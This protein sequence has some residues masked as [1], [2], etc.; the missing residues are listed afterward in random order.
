MTHLDKNSTEIAQNATRPAAMEIAM[1]LPEILSNV[2]Y[3]V[4]RSSLRACLQVSRHWYSCGR[5]ISWQTFRIPLHLFACLFCKPHDLGS[6]SVDN[7][8]IRNFLDG[9]RHIRSL[10]LDEPYIRDW[11]TTSDSV[12][13]MICPKIPFVLEVPDLSN[14]MHFAV[15]VF[16][17]I[18]Q[19][20][21]RLGKLLHVAQA[22]LLQ[23]PG[24]R[25]L[26]WSTRSELEQDFVDIVLKRASKHLKKLSLE[27]P[28]RI[29]H[30]LGYLIDANMK[31]LRGEQEKDRKKDRRS[32]VQSE[33]SQTEE[34]VLDGTGKENGE[35]QS[36]NDNDDTMGGCELEELVL[37][38]RD[39]GHERHF[40]DPPVDLTWLHDVQGTLPIHT[41]TMIDLKL[42]ISDDP[43]DEDSIQ[44]DQDSDGSLLTILSKCP[45][46]EKLCVTSNV[47]WDWI[48]CVPRTFI[49][50]IRRSLPFIKSSKLDHV[51]FERDEFVDLMYE[52]CPKLRDIEFAMAY[53]LSA[54]HW[55]EM[56]DKYGSQLESL[57]IWGNVLEFNSTALMTLI[58][59]PIS[60]PSRKTLHCLTRLNING[61]EH[62]HDSAWMVLQHLPQLKEF[63]ARDIPLDARELI[64]DGGWACK[65]LEV[66]EIFIA[67][68]TKPQWIWHEPWNN[69]MKNDTYARTVI[70]M[71][72]SDI[73]GRNNN[74][75][76]QLDVK[77]A[78]KRRAE[79]TNTGSSR[80][81]RKSDKQ[82]EEEKV[83]TKGKEPRKHPRQTGVGR[84]GS[85]ESLHTVIQ[86]QVCR[87]LGLLTQLRELKIE[88][89]KDF[90]FASRTWDCLDLTLETGLG[91]LAPLR[92]NLE[93]LNVSSLQNGLTGRKEVEWIARNWIH[94]NNPRWLKRYSKLR[95]P[96]PTPLPKGV[97]GK[98]GPPGT[99]SKDDDILTTYQRP[100]FTEL[101]GI[102]IPYIGK[103]KAISNMA[104]LLAQCPS[105]SIVEVGGRRRKH[106]WI[107]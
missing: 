46:L 4:D 99:G 75:C 60:H 90:R 44:D 78:L 47:N 17:T 3:F 77:G 103:E 80:K 71:N 25:E 83:K 107:D 56:M 30:I 86:I 52:Y 12:L 106:E 88:G 38:G 39:A 23:N 74:I 97:S 42:P 73:M 57:S 64:M 15:R 102:L 49:H 6:S 72:W 105:L 104:W 8:K 34:S 22:V 87:M 28:P 36:V 67:V 91:L 29:I 1:S 10:T 11:L 16:P 33:G 37:N 5:A 13:P 18:S 31:R 59:P 45:N 85:Y 96:T 94:Y 14:L 55:I 68:P 66:L 35:D 19:D 61:M 40:F 53:H 54:G 100:K 65:G 41:L 27:G 26:E 79:E 93:A 50:E 89:Q 7:D 70:P 76:E 21:E 2:L 24:I 63:R 20:I 98:S 48:N 92:Q 81:R 95:K 32:G 84:S 9:S 43:F 58:G 101:I 62:L 82:P 51:E 69:W